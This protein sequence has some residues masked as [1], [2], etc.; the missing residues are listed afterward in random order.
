MLKNGKLFGKINVIDFL[1][2][3]AVVVVIA[4]AAVFVLRPKDGGDTLIIKFRIEE[5]DGFVAKK[6]HSGDEMYDDTNLQDIG[7]VT[8]VELSDSISYG[9]V[10][11]NVYTLTS[12]EGYYSMIITGEVKGRKTKLGAEI[13]GKKYG[14]GHSMVLR[15]GDAKMYL[16]VYDIAL[17]DDNSNSQDD[18][19]SVNLTPVNLTFYTEETPEFVAE[20]IKIGDKAVDAARRSTALGIINTV[21]T[22]EAVIF[23]ETDSGLLE[24]AKPGYVSMTLETTIDAELVDGGVKIGERVYSVGDE[25]D[26]RAGSSRLTMTVRSIG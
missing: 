4:A 14:V 19:E 26:M 16:R 12:K 20:N 6:V 21:E 25:I 10:N 3:L 11:D 24:C 5:V 1:A 8:D 23:A 22:G 2:I 7:V 9:Q 15:A 17:K 18:G 13:G